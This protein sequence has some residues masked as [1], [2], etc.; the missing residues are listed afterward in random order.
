MKYVS[1]VLGIISFLFMLIGLIPCFGWLNWILT[2][3]IALIGLGIA[4]WL[5]Q[6]NEVNKQDSSI[7]IGLYLN[8]CA[9]IV[10]IIKLFLGGGFF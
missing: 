5:Y 8:A 9:L 4:Y 7:K 6:Q 1:I 10:G 2:I 3:P